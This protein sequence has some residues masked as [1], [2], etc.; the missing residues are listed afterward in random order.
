MS[1]LSER[2]LRHALTITVSITR[3]VTKVETI[4]SFINVAAK[5]IHHFFCAGH[6]YLPHCLMTSG[7]STSQVEGLLDCDS[8]GDTNGT[9]FEGYDLLPGRYAFD[10]SSPA[11]MVLAQ[12]P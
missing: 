6:R 9:D 12:L 10:V 1:L 5:G 11:L 2:A 4:I 8:S 3:C 7:V